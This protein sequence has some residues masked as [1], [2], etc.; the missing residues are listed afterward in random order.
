[1]GGGSLTVDG[2]RHSTNIALRQ[3]KKLRKYE[4]EQVCKIPG[5]SVT[6]LKA[7]LVARIE[8]YIN[9]QF[10]LV[11]RSGAGT[12]LAQARVLTEVVQEVSRGY[13]NV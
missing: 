12:A 2:L 11:A 1:A 9:N 6:G 5:L 3:L 7:T 13:A 4:L 10:S 8:G